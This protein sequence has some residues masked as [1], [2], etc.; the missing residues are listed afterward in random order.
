MNTKALQVVFMI[1]ST[2]A[3]I[4]KT[5]SLERAG[6]P[7]QGFD[8]DQALMHLMASHKSDDDEGLR[9]KATGTDGAIMWRK[10]VG[11]EGLQWPLN[12][13]RVGKARSSLSSYRRNDVYGVAGRFGRSA[14]FGPELI[15]D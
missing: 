12:S 11:D 3:L 10:P 13:K 2:L 4:A 14:E 15:Q 1:M 8:N 5:K 6:D 9:H 7:L